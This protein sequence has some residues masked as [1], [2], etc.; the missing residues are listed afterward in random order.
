LVDEL[1]FSYLCVWDMKKMFASEH[2]PSKEHSIG[3]SCHFI[4]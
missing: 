3:W 2:N 4:L 1:D